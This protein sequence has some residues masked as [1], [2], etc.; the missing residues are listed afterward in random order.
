MIVSSGIMLWVC[1]GGLDFHLW[2]R[3]EFLTT[4]ADT[5]FGSHM[6]TLLPI[7]SVSS[8]SRCSASFDARYAMAALTDSSVDM[9]LSLFICFSLVSGLSRGS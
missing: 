8:A 3:G 1:L 9:R 6:H 7:T 2:R 5:S 4:R